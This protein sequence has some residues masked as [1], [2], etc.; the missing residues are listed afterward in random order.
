MS[1]SSLLKS[2]FLSVFLMGAFGINAQ[3]KGGVASDVVIFGKN[4]TKEQLLQTG[5]VIKCATTEY[6][7]RL[8]AK[9]PNRLTDAQFE[10]WLAPLVEKA[11]TD[12]SQ[13]NG[14]ITIPVVVH[15]IH[16]GQNVGFGPNISDN[17]VI[18]QITAMNNDFR[19][20][21]FTRGENFNPVGADVM[22][23]FA[24]AKVD[25]NG[26]PTNGID[27]VNLCA[28]SWSGDDVDAKVKPQTIWD[29]AQYLNMWTV[30]FS[31][32][33]LLG[34]AQFPS[35]SGLIGM[36]GN[37][38]AANTDGVVSTYK[39]FGSADFNDGTFNLQSGSNYGRTMTHEVGHYLGLRHLWGDGDCSVDDFCAD[40][41][42][43]SSAGNAHYSCNLN[44]DSCPTSPGLDMVQ[45]YMNYSGDDCMNIFTNDQKIRMTAVMNNSPRRTTLK[46]SVTDLP[47]AL[48]PND[49]EVKIEN[50]C[51]GDCNVVVNSFKLTLYNRGTSTLTSAAINYTYNNGAPQIYNFSGSLAQDKFSTVTIAVPANTVLTNITA[52]VQSVNGSAD[53]RASNNTATKSFGAPQYAM[54]SVV[55]RLQQDVYGDETNWELKNS[56]GA[57]VKSGG[58]YADTSAS[59]PSLPLLISE[60]W[61]L[62]LDDCYTFTIYDSYG[63]GINS[64]SGNGF[65]D[66]KSPDGTV[67]IYSGGNFASQEKVS[68]RLVSQMSTSETAGNNFEVFPIPV[69]DI[70]NITKVSN[71]AQYTVFS[72]AGQLVASGLVKDNKV[73]VSAL[74]TGTYI[75]SVKDK[76]FTGTVKFIKK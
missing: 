65:F 11:K 30:N 67:I 60:S 73:N 17:Q 38:G 6:E 20:V 62:P 58:P 45:N 10:A 41:P 23:Q 35:G 18:S 36:P 29:P 52:N 24:L 4:Y 47:I 57:I 46:T 14:I 13:N 55:F 68:F 63:D 16:S 49:A 26:N 7:A 39:A 53:Q 43:S 59:F 3:K 22:I 50:I 54:P 32:S 25:P 34:Y 15:V 5:G 69:T 19:K 71:R 48:F 74:V 66:L 9:D 27:R 72:A 42:N 1:K 8:Q 21:P 70:L 2:L 33:G 31:G 12:K 37:G 56:A 76:E 40:T 64:G 61:N 75:I 44:Q 28:A 51:G